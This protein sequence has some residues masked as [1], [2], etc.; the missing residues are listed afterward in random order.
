MAG[1]ADSPSAIRPRPPSPGDV[2]HRWD[3][4]ARLSSLTCG[5]AQNVPY[6]D[7]RP[8]RRIHVQPACADLAAGG[9]LLIGRGT[10]GQQKGSKRPKASPRNPAQ[11]LR[12][13]SADPHE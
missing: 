8:L 6:D 2:F 11:N 1:P 5:H 12:R 3:D 13:R 7:R 9:R 4:D 10:S